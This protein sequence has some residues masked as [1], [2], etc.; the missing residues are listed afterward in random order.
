MFP[1]AEAPCPQSL[2]TWSTNQ[3]SGPKMEQTR[4]LGPYNYQGP[5]IESGTPSSVVTHLEPQ[6]PAWNR[7]TAGCSIR[8]VNV[9]SAHANLDK[10]SGSCS[11]GVQG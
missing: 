1:K 7:F 2:L 3:A 6:D 9:G 5:L 10:D 8:G 4:E 11:W